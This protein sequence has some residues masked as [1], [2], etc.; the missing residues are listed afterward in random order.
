M[1]FG[2]KSSQ[3]V[4]RGLCRRRKPGWLDALPKLRMVQEQCSNFTGFAHLLSHVHMNAYQ[5]A[6]LGLQ[7]HFYLQSSSCLLRAG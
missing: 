7:C 4:I 2:G 6:R 5:S 3:R 1:L